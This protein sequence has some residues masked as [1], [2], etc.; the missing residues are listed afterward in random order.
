MSYNCILTELDEGPLFISNLLDVENKPLPG[1]SSL[2][3]RATPMLEHV[4]SSVK[5]Y[6]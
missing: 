1:L 2:E 3:W 4:D 6:L 5:R